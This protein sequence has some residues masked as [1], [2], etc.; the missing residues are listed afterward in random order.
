MASKRLTGIILKTARSARG[1]RQSDIASEL[2][3]TSAAL[4]HIE[5]G[6]NTASRQVLQAYAERLVG[7]RD[8]GRLVKLLEPESTDN[9]AKIAELI[10]PSD[11]KAFEEFVREATVPSHQPR[12]DTSWNFASFDAVPLRALSSRTIREERSATL[13]ERD[14]LT[15]ALR[16][17]I[18]DRGGRTLIAGRDSSDFGMG[19]SVKCD[20]IE[21]THSLVIEIRAANRS[22][23]RVIP[24]LVGKSVLLNEQGFKF[25][26]CFTAPPTSRLDEVAMATVRRFGAAVIWAQDGGPREIGMTGFGG[27]TIL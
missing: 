23:A 2:G 9:L 12:H 14:A 24:E 1:I 25:V 7:N 3:V 27:D 15:K 11:P 22:E 21:T 8:A 4:S 26:L 20:L 18:A 16:H 13:D 17:F 19:F 6:R 10:N 5:A